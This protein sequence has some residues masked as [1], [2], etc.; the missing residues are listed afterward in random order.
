MCCGEI[1]NE[2]GNGVK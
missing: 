1:D 2:E